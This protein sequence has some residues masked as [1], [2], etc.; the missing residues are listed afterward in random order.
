MRF[1]QGVGGNE[2]EYAGSL[3]TGRLMTIT[4]KGL[5]EYEN[6]SGVFFRFLSPHPFNPCSLIFFYGAHHLRSPGHLRSLKISIMRTQV[7]SITQRRHLDS[8]STL[9]GHIIH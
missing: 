3:L 4:A 1:T 2:Q 7:A 5:E 6:E 8:R 9:I